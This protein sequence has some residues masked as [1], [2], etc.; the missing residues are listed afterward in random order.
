MRGWLTVL[1]LLPLL[2]SAQV[3]VGR[4]QRF[5]SAMPPGNYSGI[6]ALGSDR[7][8]LVDDKA[9]H[10][11][12]YRYHIVIDTLSGKIR[13]V[14]NE[15]FLP[16]GSVNGDME[17]VAYVPALNTIFA[18]SEARNEIVGYPVDGGRAVCS[19]Q[20]PDVYTR[21][22]SSYGLESLTYDASSHLL[23]TTTERPVRGD[24]LLRLQSFDLTL[25][26]RRQYAY[27]IDE[28]QYLPKGGRYVHGVSE[29][30]ALG[31]G[32]LLVMEREVYVPKKKIGARVHVKIYEVQPSWLEQLPKRL[33]CEFTT[34]MNLTSRSFANYEGMCVAHR[35]GDGRV[36]LLLVA[37]S[38]GRYKGVV[39]DWLRTIIL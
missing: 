2:T 13:G 37:D 3:R 12:F 20:M 16:V 33:V 14:E 21:A 22:S 38:Q 8:L 29:L 25:L 36:L 17:A 9:P 30:C 19:V 28:P 31:D 39:R 4:Q 1:M 32:R 23:W 10:D 5:H 11:G 15:G 18:C 7:F 34:K 24:S 6:T 35:Y 26:P 27:R